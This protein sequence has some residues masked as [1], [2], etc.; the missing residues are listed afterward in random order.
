MLITWFQGFVKLPGSNTLN[1]YSRLRRYACVDSSAALKDIGNFLPALNSS[2]DFVEHIF[3]LDNVNGATMM[4]VLIACSR[5]K[6]VRR[7]TA[8]SKQR[9]GQMLAQTGSSNCARGA[10]VQIRNSLK[11]TRTLSILS[12]VRSVKLALNHALVEGEKQLRLDQLD[13][14]SD[15]IMLDTYTI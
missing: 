14:C 5:D 15:E 1:A 12:Q 13:A 3:E 9:R 11:R 6:D 7:R 10:R 4:A 8:Q 2:L